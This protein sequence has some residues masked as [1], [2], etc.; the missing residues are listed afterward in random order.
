M[1]PGRVPNLIDLP[2]GCRFAPRCQARIE[3]GLT[4]C[5]EDVPALVEVEP[6][7]KVR[8]FLHSDAA[9][10]PV[11]SSER[12][13]RRSSR[14]EALMKSFPVQSG[15]FGEALRRGAGRRRRRPRRATPGEVLGLVGE[16][17]CGKS[18]LGR[19]RAA[20]ARTRRRDDPLR[21]QGPRGGQ[22]G[23]A[24][25]AAPEMQI[26]FQDP[27]SSLDPRATV[28]DSIAEGLA[29]ARRAEAAAARSGSTR[30][31]RSSGSSRT[32]PAGTRISSAA[33]SASASASPAR[34]RSSPASS[35]PTSPSRRSTC[36]SSRRS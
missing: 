13:G 21:R 4:Q 2:P 18:T 12:S 19:A 33:A 10:E 30:C 25:G 7:H 17:G 24:A 32:T 9:E 34:W 31:S 26:I 16:S 6:G 28:G 35:S 8:C 27:Y 5:T 23:R 29:G 1:I 36:R 14:C 11:A 22:G 20:P 3:A 15:V